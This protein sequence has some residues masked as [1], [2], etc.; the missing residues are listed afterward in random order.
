MSQATNEPK[1]ENKPGLFTPITLGKR[2]LRNR[3]VFLPHATGQGAQGLPS[4]GH[5]AYFAR[6]AEGGVGMIIQEATPVHQASLSRPTHVQGYD[7]RIIGPARKISD[8]VHKGGA[9]MLVQI[10]HRGL[11]ALPVFSRMPVWAPSPSRSPHTGEMA[12]AVTLSEIRE[13]VAGFVQTAKNF[14]EGGYDGVEIHCTHGHLLNSFMNPRLNW[15]NDAYGGSVE[16]RMRLLIEVLQALRALPLGILGIRFGASA[17]NAGPEAG[18]TATIIRAIEPYVDYISVTGGTQATKH[19]NMADMYSPPAYMLELAQQVK[20]MTTRPVIA[21]GRLNDPALAVS[22]IES[23]SI[24][25]VG[26]ARGLICDP[27][28]ARKV[29]QKAA[30]EIRPCIACNTCVD[31]AESGGPIGCIYNPRTGREGEVAARPANTTAANK[32]VLVVGG[33]AAGMQAALR[34]EELGFR[35]TLAEAGATLGGQIALSAAIPG[36]E[37]FQQIGDFLSDA[38]AKSH[39]DVLLGKRFEAGAPEFANYDGVII[40]TGASPASLSDSTAIAIPRFQAEAIL[41][42]PAMATGQRALLIVDDGLTSGPGAAELL[43]KRG[44]EV[45]VVLAGAELGG[46]LPYTNRRTLMD[47]LLAL[48]LHWHFHSTLL[49]VDKSGKATLTTR[50][51]GEVALDGTFDFVVQTLQRSANSDL[52]SVLETAG[53]IK[54]AAGGDCVAPRNIFHAVREGFDAADRLAAALS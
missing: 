14:S 35:V 24:D 7:P 47:R 18:D 46:A 10:S 11:A 50:G 45:H 29:Q 17:W 28:W 4:E 44:V 21:A 49:G 37:G 2:T 30:A 15:R 32:R 25:L 53:N 41:Q 48:P 42:N 39:V 43:A 54:F 51:A 40:T 34:A 1:N 20:R 8:A 9:M 33:G 12:H 6:R 13:I 26:L 3:I 19:L 16:N 27:D 36:R 23:G 22:V 52:I 31:R 5:L 38:L